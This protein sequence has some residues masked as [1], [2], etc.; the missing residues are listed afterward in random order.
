MAITPVDHSELH[1][2]SATGAVRL[3]DGVTFDGTL[4][5]GDFL[6][7]APTRS[8]R[9]H[10]GAPGYRHFVIEA[11]RLGGHPLL[12]SLCFY[13]ETLLYAEFYAILDPNGPTSYADASLETEAQTKRFHEA[14]LARI[15]GAPHRVQPLPSRKLPESQQALGYH[16]SYT[17]PWGSVSS[18]HDERSLTTAIRV[19]YGDRLAEANVAYLQDQARG[20]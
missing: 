12:A 13:R 1:I 2:D 16:L 4:T 5:R 7:A 15:L 6:D 9:T 18:Y 19:A 14:H 10:D 17:Y 3:P 11:G 8:A 20:G